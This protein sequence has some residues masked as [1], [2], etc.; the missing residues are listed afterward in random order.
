MDSSKAK[1]P[2]ASS[3]DGYSK[4][5]PFNPS[6]TCSKQ[7]CDLCGVNICMANDHRSS[8]PVI[9]DR[10]CKTCFYCNGAGDW[11]NHIIALIESIEDAV[12]EVEVRKDIR[13]EIKTQLIEL[14]GAIIR[15][16]GSF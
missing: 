8:T 14:C 5:D 4:Y 1:S 9:D 11:L 15:R 2:N 10:P 16:H 7:C 12:D 13:N 6:H 3:D